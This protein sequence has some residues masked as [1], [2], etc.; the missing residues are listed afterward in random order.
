MT[1][2]GSWRPCATKLQVSVL[3]CLRNLCEDLDARRMVSKAIRSERLRADGTSTGRRE[4]LGVFLLSLLSPSA[5][6]RAD[7]CLML[8]LLMTKVEGDKE[9]RESSPTPFA[10]AVVAVQQTRLLRRFMSA[11]RPTSSTVL[12]GA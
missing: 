3:G 2:R 5:M 9:V 7:A 8:K 12:E 11:F 10:A 4:K 1:A 6:A